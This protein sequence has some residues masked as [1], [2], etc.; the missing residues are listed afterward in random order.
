MSLLSKKFCLRLRQIAWLGWDLERGLL[1]PSGQ[2]CLRAG[3]R[4]WRYG[5]LGGLAPLWVLEGLLGLCGP[6]PP[7]CLC[8]PALL[9]CFRIMSCLSWAP[10]RPPLLLSALTGTLSLPAPHSQHHVL[11]PRLSRI[12]PSSLCLPLVFSS[13]S[14]FPPLHT[15][16]PCPPPQGF[17]EAFSCPCESS[18]C[19]LHFD[20]P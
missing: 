10:C 16:T 19:S 8:L 9:V 5:V 13:L 2:W 12:S 20:K 11:T 3:H 17:P 15:P 1:L 6:H 14:P 4:A 7:E 18:H